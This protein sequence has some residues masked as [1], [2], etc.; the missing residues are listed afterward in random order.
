MLFDD[1]CKEFSDK[2]CDELFDELFDELCR[3]R[4]NEIGD[5]LLYE[6]L[7][8]GRAFKIYGAKMKVSTT[9]ANVYNGRIFCHIWGVHRH[10]SRYLHRVST[11]V[12]AIC[13][14]TIGRPIYGRHST[15]AVYRPIRDRCLVVTSP[16]YHRRNTDTPLTYH[17]VFSYT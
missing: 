14:P 11:K 17:R 9:I 10:S 2:L 8:I 13:Q 1:L 16:R 12:S 5:K 3:E 4:C 7:K 15:A 6:V